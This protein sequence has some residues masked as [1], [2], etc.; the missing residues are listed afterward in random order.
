MRR[1]HAPTYVQT[2]TC[3][4]LPSL[5]STALAVEVC[6]GEQMVGCA[7][8]VLAQVLAQ[9]R[10]AIQLASG[11]GADQTV[12]RGTG[13]RQSVQCVSR[14]C[15]IPSGQAMAELTLQLTLEDFG[16][17]STQVGGAVCTDERGSTQVGGVW[18]GTGGVMHRVVPRQCQL[19]RANAC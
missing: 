15:A 6:S 13:L 8:V 2:G 19:T 9:P 1:V 4:A 12:G 11:G 18:G 17:P 3:H 7:H 5:C 10:T 16:P 14:V